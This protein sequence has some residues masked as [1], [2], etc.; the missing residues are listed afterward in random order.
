M[1]GRPEKRSLYSEVGFYTTDG[2]VHNAVLRTWVDVEFLNPQTLERLR[3]LGKVVNL[4]SKQ[5]KMILTLR[6]L[7]GKEFVLNEESIASYRP[8]A[9]QAH[10][11]YGA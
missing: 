1:V 5:M 9:R 4:G 11:K 3:I 2:T 6:D 10:K 8:R 7:D